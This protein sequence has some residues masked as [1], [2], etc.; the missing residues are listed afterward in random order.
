MKISKLSKCQ[1]SGQDYGPSRL[2]SDNLKII[3]AIIQILCIFA[4]RFHAGGFIPQNKDGSVAQLD[5]AT[6]F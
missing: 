5:R 1:T 4:V 2:F 3:I 6:A